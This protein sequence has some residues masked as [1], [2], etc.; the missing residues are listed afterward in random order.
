MSSFLS[1]EGKRDHITLILN[2]DWFRCQ[3]DLIDLRKLV[4]G[5]QSQLDS[6]IAV[7]VTV[8]S[9]EE[10]VIDGAADIVNVSNQSRG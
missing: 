10:T 5:L 7:N 2:S 1:R 9:K 3:I 8:E 4:A 6:M